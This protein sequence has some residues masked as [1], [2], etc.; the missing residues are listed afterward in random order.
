MIRWRWPMRISLTMIIGAPL[1]K[2]RSAGP[3]GVWRSSEELYEKF[4]QSFL[5]PDQGQFP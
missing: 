5:H 1:A 3:M 2:A 4:L